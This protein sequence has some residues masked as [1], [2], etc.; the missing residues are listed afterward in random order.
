MSSSEGRGLQQEQIYRAWQLLLENKGL[1]YMPVGGFNLRLA[2]GCL[3]AQCTHIARPC[4]VH[5]R[6]TSFGLA[7]IQIQFAAQRPLQC[8]LKRRKVKH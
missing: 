8:E 7:K 4:Q 5:L 2:P 3:L 6:G 1:H